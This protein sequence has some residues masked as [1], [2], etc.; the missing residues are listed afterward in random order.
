MTSEFMGPPWQTD[1]TKEAEKNHNALPEEAR[2]LVHAARA[3]NTSSTSTTGAA[4]SG[5]TSYPAPPTR[6]S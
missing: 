5:T 2:A 1:W 3:A 6:R 4:G